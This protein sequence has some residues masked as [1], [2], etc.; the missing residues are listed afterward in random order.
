M[1]QVDWTARD[2]EC[3]YDTRITSLSIPLCC[4][5]SWLGTQSGGVR[6][7]TIP[8]IL[9]WPRTGLRI[10]LSLTH[11]SIIVTGLK[12]TLRNQRELGQK[13]SHSSSHGLVQG[14]K[15]PWT[16][17]G[18]LSCRI[19]GLKIT[20][21][22]TQPSILA[23]KI[24]LRNHRELGQNPTHSS[25]YGL[26]QGSKL[27]RTIRGGLSCII[28]GLKITLSLTQPSILAFKITLRNQR[29]LGQ[30]PTL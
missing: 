25:S 2:K 6:P 30:T 3:R 14:S 13:P 1:W 18:G 22:L 10:T 7:K 9:T 27:P 29:E 21:S 12:I 4:Y 28:V 11:A 26:V 8:F 23:F 19:I 17:R 15:L 24:T 20:L 16:I 5:W